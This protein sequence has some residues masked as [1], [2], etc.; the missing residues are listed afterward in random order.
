M[1]QVTRLKGEEI[2]I[3]VDRILFIERTP[4]TTIILDNGQRVMVQQSPAEL[5]ES[6]VAFRKRIMDLNV[7]ES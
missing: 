2:F 1:I 6:I 7:Q 3:N 4:D 5:V